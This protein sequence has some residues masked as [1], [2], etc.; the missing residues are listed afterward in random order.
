MKAEYDFSQGK[1]GAVI[2]QR[3]K[4]RITIY[5]DNDVLEAFRNRADQ[6]G[7]GYQTMINQALRDFLSNDPGPVTE[8]T[9]RRVLR[10]ELQMAP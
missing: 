5:L 4:T 9:L 6:A 7:M 3:G 1:R 8:K 2:P 10:E